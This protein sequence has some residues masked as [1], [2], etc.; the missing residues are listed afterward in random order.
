MIVY[1]SFYFRMVYLI[2]LDLDL[3]ALDIKGTLMCLHFT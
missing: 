2:G 3:M 1:V